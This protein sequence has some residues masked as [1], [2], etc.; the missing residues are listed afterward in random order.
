MLLPNTSKTKSQ[1]TWWGYHHH[2]QVVDRLE[3]ARKW[4]GLILL[5]AVVVPVVIWSMSLGRGAGQ[6]SLFDSRTS[7]GEVTR[8]HSA[9]DQQCDACHQPFQPMQTEKPLPLMQGLTMSSLL[10]NFV[11]EEEL[12]YT[13]DL[14]CQRCHETLT[15]HDNMLTRDV[16][17]CADC[18]RD[19]QG[20]NVRLTSLDDSAC[21]RCHSDLQHH[22]EHE[23]ANGINAL[24]IAG[25]TRGHPEFR[26]VAPLPPD[27]KQTELTSHHP[28]GL[29]FSH[30]VHMQLGMGLKR[31][32]PREE[33]A[34]TGMAF[35]YSEIDAAVRE[36]YLKGRTVGMDDP[37]Q[38]DCHD[39]HQLD[40]GRLTPTVAAID[41]LPGEMLLPPRGRGGVYLPIVFEKH[42][43]GC[44]PLGYSSE[45]NSPTVPHR[46]Q[47]PEVEHFL[48]GEFS[49]RLV[50][51]RLKQRLEQ[52]QRP[53]RLDPPLELLTEE[54]RQQLRNEAE[55][56]AKQASE[57][58]FALLAYAAPAAETAIEDAAVRLFAGRTTCG[59]CHFAE[60][61]SASGLPVP[62]RIRAVNTPTIW[63]PRARFDH[64]SHE[65]LVCGVCH[66]RSASENLPE[67]R[68]AA[69]ANSVTKTW[70]GVY[71]HPPDLPS[72]ELC[73]KCHAPV[74]RRER[75]GGISHRC[76]D[77]HTYHGAQHGLQGRGAR[78]ITD[79]NHKVDDPHKMLFPELPGLK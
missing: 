35:R 14:R 66:P 77:C 15:H 76:T 55:Q 61:Q 74:N 30:A 19:H 34:T 71:Q 72:I 70:D 37:V 29:K 7:P 8:A 11:P 4:S 67:E 13:A 17:Q 22:R 57:N 50:T 40:A 73:Q 27:A 68:A 45:A 64:L 36:Q 46:L 58:L 38:L 60:G 23:L 56:E 52:P 25:F 47:P 75:T 62:E 3:Q 12:A 39:C 28:R 5:L 33:T 26:A 53:P 16:G 31:T 54:D 51:D 44:H 21:T 69:L 42:C 10:S 43:R 18:H 1:R 63:Q 41:G 6:A 24:A 65:V 59:E 49:Q 2:D 32:D 79:P 78:R 9:W 48:L 20:K